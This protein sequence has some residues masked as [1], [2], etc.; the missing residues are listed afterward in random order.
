MDSR[1][2]AHTPFSGCDMI[3][4]LSRALAG[5]G[6]LFATSQVAAQDIYSIHVD[7]AQEKIVVTGVDLDL[8]TTVTLGGVAVIP[9]APVASGQ[10]EIPFATAVYDAVQWQGSYNLVLDGSE[11]LSVYIDAPIEA[12]PGPPV[13]GL[14]CAC[15][16]GWQSQ[17]SVIA[18]NEA[19]CQPISDGNQVGYVGSSTLAF[20][21]GPT[22][23]WLA[24]AYDYDHP[25]D[26]DYADP[27]SARSFCAL[28]VDAD[29][30][31]EVA[32]PVTNIDQYDDC[33]EWLFSE[34][35]CF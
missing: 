28:D 25:Q 10:M 4:T 17:A 19:F 5:A 32:E 22:P 34:L 9:A 7:R 2:Q 30:T 15:I 23:W 29:G 21:P 18:N 3:A 16:G 11:R 8:A 12:P 20:N 31:F 27:G 14:D 26:F 24:V 35:V 33:V 13:G 6:L 1:C